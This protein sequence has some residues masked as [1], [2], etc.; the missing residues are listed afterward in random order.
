V[1]S[2][3]ILFIHEVLLYANDTCLHSSLCVLLIYTDYP[4]ACSLF[5][6]AQRISAREYVPS[7]EDILR[8]HEKPGVCVT[9]LDNH[10]IRLL[11]VNTRW[12]TW[13]KW[14][15]HFEGVI[16]IVFCASLSD[17]DRE[18]S[19]IDNHVC[20]VIVITRPFKSTLA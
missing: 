3:F 14:M 2:Y 5:G 18:V 4:L 20:I 17:Y 15:H 16:S 19:V 8:I 10:R 13:K 12:N 6:Q 9:D 1:S 11:W 7:S